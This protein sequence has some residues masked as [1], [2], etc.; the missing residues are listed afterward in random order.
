MSCILIVDN[1]PLN[2]EL[3]HA[4]LDGDG[5]TLLEAESGESALALAATH[6][7]DIVL[8]DVMMPGIGGFRTARILKERAGARFLPIILLTSLN[9]TLSRVEGLNHGAD[10]F[11]TK[12]FDG[13]ELKLRIRNLLALREKET[14]VFELARFREE[15]SQLLV[16]DLKGPLSACA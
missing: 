3:L 14:A 5:N 7:P 13:V 11:L 12:P 8:L 2:R 6:P 15:M 4:H 9:D 16:H 10:D 1:D